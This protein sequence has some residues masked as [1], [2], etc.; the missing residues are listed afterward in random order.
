MN[1]LRRFNAFYFQSCCITCN[2]VRVRLTY[3]MIRLAYM[4]KK[5]LHFVSSIKLH[6]L[7]QTETRPC[8]FLFFICLFF[9]KLRVA[10]LKCCSYRC[11]FYCLWV[12]WIVNPTCVLNHSCDPSVLVYFISDIH[13]RLKWLQKVLRWFIAW[14]FLENENSSTNSTVL[15]CTQF[16]NISFL[17]TRR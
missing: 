7:S 12:L 13:S 3:I 9:Q 10:A 16:Y 15:K 17:Q 11:L 4:E 6:P 2:I 5:T 1:M 8:V 14:R